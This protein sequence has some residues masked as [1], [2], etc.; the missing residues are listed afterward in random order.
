MVINVSRISLC[1]AVFIINLERETMPR[2]GS[3][4]GPG[5][6]LQVVWTVPWWCHGDLIHV[7]TS[8]APQGAGD[9]AAA[10]ISMQL[11][12]KEFPNTSPFAA[13]QSWRI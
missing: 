9:P 12:S 13:Y 10:Y 5:V 4:A 3:T 8:S 1:W 11:S 2:F 6:W 7:Q